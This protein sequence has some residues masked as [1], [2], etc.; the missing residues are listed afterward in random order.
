MVYPCEVGRKNYNI[1]FD[2]QGLE[3]ILEIFP[4]LNRKNA[5][6]ITRFER[7]RKISISNGSN[8]WGSFI[9]I[10]ESRVEGSTSIVIP[11]DKGGSNCFYNA[12]DAFFGKS[13]NTDTIP[14][15]NTLVH[16]KVELSEDK[17]SAGN[18]FSQ[19]AGGNEH[20]VGTQTS[21]E[22]IAPQNNEEHGIQTVALLQKDSVLSVKEIDHATPGGLTTEEE[23]LKACLLNH[24]EQMII[25]GLFKQAPEVEVS[26]TDDPIQFELKLMIIDDNVEEPA[27]GD[28]QKEFEIL[29]PIFEQHI[30]DDFEQSLWMIKESLRSPFIKDKIQKGLVQT[31]QGKAIK[32]TRDAMKSAQCIRAIKIKGFRDATLYCNWI[33]Y[34]PVLIDLHGLGVV[35]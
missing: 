18:C 26:R 12:V 20:P 10:L 8:R 7:Q 17:A 32:A 16:E 9:R 30:S 15:A 23:S 29:K 6:A 33:L 21:L 31:L 3:W 25:E 28:L 1:W 11:V 34:C 5:W 24:E 27:S 19:G 4:K 22:F 35:T 14:N 13:K 2:F